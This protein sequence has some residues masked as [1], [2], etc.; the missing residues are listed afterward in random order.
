M[1]WNSSFHSRKMAARSWSWKM[2][3]SSPAS[4]RE[5]AFMK[6]F[7]RLSSAVTQSNISCKDAV[8]ALLEK[9]VRPNSCRPA[10]SGVSCREGV[11]VSAPTRC[12][13]G[14]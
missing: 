1:A 5:C 3:F 11:P 12:A 10:G 8:S 6:A 4:W 7:L 2:Y 13:G 9:T 14:G